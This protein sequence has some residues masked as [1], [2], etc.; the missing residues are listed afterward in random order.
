MSSE[1]KRRVVRY[2]Q[3]DRTLHNHRCKNLKSC[4]VRMLTVLPTA[5]HVS[6]HTCT[7]PLGVVVV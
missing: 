3:E 7:V 5:V 6:L 2:I 4:I 1:I